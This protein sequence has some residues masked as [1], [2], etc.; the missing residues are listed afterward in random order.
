MRA[1]L[2]AAL[3]ASLAACKDEELVCRLDTE[4]VGGRGE[5]GLCLESHCAFRDGDCSGGYRWDDASGA[6]SDRCADTATVGGHL[7]GGVRFDARPADAS[8]AAGAP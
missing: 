4:C 8:V 7:D 3:L 1:L 2:F 5:F 6:L